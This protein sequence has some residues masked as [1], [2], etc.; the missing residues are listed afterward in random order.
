[1]KSDCFISSYIFT[2]MFRMD[3]KL[4]SNIVTKCSYWGQFN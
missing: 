3:R 4:L 2:P 1:M